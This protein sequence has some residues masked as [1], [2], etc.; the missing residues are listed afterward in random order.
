MHSA[1]TGD[2]A[3][4][5]GRRRAPGGAG[6]VAGT[7][8]VAVAGLTNRSSVP[9]EA[10][11]LGTYKWGRNASRLHAGQSDGG[12]DVITAWPV[13]RAFTF[14]LRGARPCGLTA[15]C[16]VVAGPFEGSGVGAAPRTAELPSTAGVGILNEGR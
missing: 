4:A 7:P 5:S 14:Q 12:I 8:G 2:P 15:R 1:A 9:N 16:T 10:L 6:S 3:G 11:T 13:V